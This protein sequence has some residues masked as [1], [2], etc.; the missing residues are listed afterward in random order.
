MHSSCPHARVNVI[1][2]TF[3]S[4]RQVDNTI[5]CHDT[6]RESTTT[7]TH[8][9]HSMESQRGLY[10][11]WYHCDVDKRS[12][13]DCRDVDRP[14]KLCFEK[15]TWRTKSPQRI[16]I[17]NWT[18]L[19]ERYLNALVAIVYREYVADCHAAGALICSEVHLETRFA[20]VRVGVGRHR[21]PEDI[22]VVTVTLPRIFPTHFTSR[23]GRS[24]EL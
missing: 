17:A 3:H 23:E 5:W 6:C 7:T 24:E 20:R 4:S 18:K 14:E 21:L 11:H 2:N 16:N 10:V 22:K 15:D 13:Y 19:L 8:P 1:P 12:N 9:S